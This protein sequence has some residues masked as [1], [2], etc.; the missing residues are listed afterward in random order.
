M[1]RDPEAVDRYTLAEAE[2]YARG[3]FGDCACVEITPG[4]WACVRPFGYPRPEFYG[5]TW[6]AAFDLAEAWH[7]RHTLRDWHDSVEQGRPE[8]AEAEE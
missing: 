5:V 8:T 4:G 6:S 2:A 1:I 7:Y 3:L